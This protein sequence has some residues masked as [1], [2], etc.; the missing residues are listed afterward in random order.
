MALCYLLTLYAFVRRTEPG[1][2][3]RW[4]ALAVGSCAL[5]MACKEVMVSAPLIVLL[6]DRT[7]VSGTVREAWRRRAGFYGALGA[8]WVLLGV[9]V[10]STSG[11]GGTAGF[12]TGVSV[13]AY[14]QTQWVAIVRYLG[15]ALWPHPLVFDYGTALASDP[16]VIAPCAL[17]VIG[18]LAATVVALRRA[19]AL[20]FLGAVFFAVLA[21]SSSLVPIATQ[22]M[23]EHRM[24]LPL[25]TVMVLVVLAAHRWLAARSAVVLGVA[26]AALALLTVQRNSDYRSNAALW[27]D[28]VAKQPLNARAH[29]G[30]ADALFVADRVD[31]ALPHY[32]EAIRL[33]P[34]DAKAHL[35]LGSALLDR[36][37]A[38]EALPELEAALRLEPT[39]AK[40]HHN[41]ANAL[42]RLNRA[43]EA[44]AHYAR[45]LQLSPGDVIAL[46]DW[47]NA[48]L[49]TGDNA[50]AIARYADAIRH[51]PNFAMAHNNLAN[52]LARTGRFAEAI[53]HYET[54]LRLEPDYAEGHNNFAAALAQS[55]RLTDAIREFE[56]ALRL[57]PDYPSAHENLG[58]LYLALG[59]K[60]A[61]DRQFALARRTPPIR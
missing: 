37:R 42:L 8:T 40:V 36:Q 60:P 57:R 31:E 4:S 6:Y 15:L 10:L 54:A 16:A 43:P 52:A 56:T 59:D 7:F 11:R 27:R 28:T 18:L 2:A 41:L 48:L 17:L 44:L 38:A 25:A 45:A 13:V 49:R 53:T 51:E 5:G 39:W 23:A 46:T 24:Y 32:A 3:A 14:A 20:G 35:N 33:N 29:S 26:A 1:A 61:A 21:P 58:K 34:D 22:T 12:G 50:G 55:G 30:L 47:G 19:P 9:L